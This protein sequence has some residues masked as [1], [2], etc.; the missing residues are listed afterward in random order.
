[1]DS[2]YSRKRVRA[3][4]DSSDD[5]STYSASDLSAPDGDNLS[6]D[7]QSDSELDGSN[8]ENDESEEVCHTH[9]AKITMKFGEIDAFSS[10]IRKVLTIL[11]NMKPRPSLSAP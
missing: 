9:W 5:G 10:L 1:M 8:A 2:H 6:N 4:K 7:S 11:R 3:R